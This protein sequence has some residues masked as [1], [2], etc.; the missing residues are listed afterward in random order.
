MSKFYEAL[1]RAKKE[2]RGNGS[3]AVS[4]AHQTD[5]TVNDNAGQS[6]PQQPGVRA[7]VKQGGP[8][9]T[10]AEQTS[11]P[12][13][14]GHGTNAVSD[15]HMID[16]TVNDNAGQSP[17]QQ[18][19]VP[20]V[21]KGG[22]LGRTDAEQTQALDIKQIDATI[23]HNVSL[24]APQQQGISIVVKDGGP[25]RT[26]AEQTQAL[27][28]K[29]YLL[30]VRKLRSLFAVVAAFIMSAA[31][32]ISYAI[33]PEYEAYTLVSVEKNF[34]SDIGKGIT[35]ASDVDAKASALF[36]IMTSR[37]IVSKVI[38]DL[39][40][41][42]GR[43]EGPEFEN[44]V[45]RIQKKTEVKIEFNKASRNAIDFF[46]VSFRDRDPKVARDYVN[47]LVERYIEENLKYKRQESSGANSF[48]L[49]QIN[50]IKAKINGLDGEIVL[51]KEKEAEIAESKI[52]QSKKKEGTALLNENRPPAVDDRLL[53]LKKLRRRLEYLVVHY[54]PDYPEVGKVKADI[55]SLKAEIKASP[56][57]PAGAHDPVS[58]SAGKNNANPTAASDVKT[59]LVELERERD[60]NKRIYDEL[61]AAYGISQVSEQAEIQDKVGR[62]RIVDPAILPLKPISPNRIMIMLLGILAGIAGAFG[63]IVFLDISDKSVK[64]VGMLKNFGLPVLVVPHILNPEEI[65]KARRRN[66]FFYG[67]SGL[68]VVLLIA[69]IVRE[70]IETLG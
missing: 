23:N 19:G 24:N 28:I 16:A 6:P 56:W 20:V 53:E 50:F 55:E 70:V 41:D 45:K 27:D 7:V 37:N 18:A 9:T 38:S 64:S 21:V 34:L 12:G 25:R 35:M 31:V 62:F 63:L 44:L 69:I 66:V 32:V 40:L 14:D 15:A 52:E 30:L 46:T 48:L 57:A 22:G 33:P 68:F 59:R 26:S 1:K 60:T 67:L 3:G 43:A 65:I 2:P 13:R 10:D 61:S 17:P 54:T 11:Y 49:S 58:R 39:D 4:D 5:V 42:L 29:R 8:R 36:T 47:T 51:L